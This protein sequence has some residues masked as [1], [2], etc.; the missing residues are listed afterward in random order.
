MNPFDVAV[1]AILVVSALFAFVRGFLKEALSI[2]VWIGAAAI[3]YYAFPFAL[4]LA[5]GLT[6][7]LWIAEAGTAIGLFVIA[8]IVLAVLSSTVA[9]R[10]RGSALG[11]IDRLL[12][13]FYGLARGAVIV[14]LVYI[15]M[16][17]LIAEPDRPGW[18]TGAQSLPA[19]ARGS[20]IL[21]HLLPPSARSLATQTVDA[22]R[23]ATQSPADLILETR[24]IL[25]ST[26]T[27]AATSPGAVQLGPS[28]S[29]GTSVSA[30]AAAGNP[31]PG[32][33]G[34]VDRLMRAPTPTVP[35]TPPEATYRPDDRKA[36]DR[37]FQ[38]V[39]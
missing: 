6:K 36:M 12:G 27:S 17:A 19:L 29:I 18:F 24:P 13:L 4:P 1:I 5:L 23:R 26:G 9:T 34:E 32:S 35:Q 30:P 8:L 10:I 2:L 14:C 15:G 28:Q 22:G 3:A 33:S 25:P 38:S 31:R 37:A 11:P 21:E 20:A 39:Q 7:Q 16:T